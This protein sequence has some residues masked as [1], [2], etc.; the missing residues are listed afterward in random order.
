MVR[1]RNLLGVIALVA[2]AFVQL[3]TADVPRSFSY[4]GRLTDALGTPL[5]GVYNIEFRIADA[6]TLGLLL[7]NSG[8]QPVTVTNGLFSVNIGEPPM[9][10]LPLDI[11]ADTNRYLSVKVGAD[12]EQSPRT[13]LTSAPY[14]YQVRTIDGATGGDVS[15]TVDLLNGSGATRVQLTPGAAQISTYG[16][17]NQEQI[18]LWGSTYGEIQLH[19]SDPS[20]DVTARLLAQSTIFADGGFLELSQTDGTP[21]IMM[22]GGSTGDLAVVLPNSSISG[23]ETLDEPGI[24]T[25]SDASAN[26]A[27]GTVNIV[28]RTINC[29]T[30]G[31]VVAL[32][33]GSFNLSHSNGTLSQYR[34]WITEVNG[35]GAAGK[36]QA[37]F[38]TSGNAPAGNYGAPLSVQGAF[39]VPAGV[40]TFY[41]RGTE[42]I[43]S[44]LCSV[45]NSSLTLMFFPTAYGTVTA[46]APE[47]DPNQPEITKAGGS[48]EEVSGAEF[49]SKRLENEVALLRKQI[50]EIRAR[51]GESSQSA[52]RE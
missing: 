47:N 1:T 25:N 43:G 20:N 3:A 24:A 37:T 14:A 29:P 12:P 51:I 5:N 30:A 52:V 44:G 2:L 42:D 13:K 15:G 18:R 40:T 38:I 7:Y 19:D 41:L 45:E 6:A 9:P 34:V 22:F 33:S 35:G 48:G 49:A 50:A 16:S 46:F 23:L 11:F 10:A 32:A 21:S 36:P 8:A 28:L 27:G 17:D 31:Y 4:Q 39:A 26:I